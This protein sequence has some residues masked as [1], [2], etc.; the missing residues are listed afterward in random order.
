MN[1]VAGLISS[2]E[3][4]HRT[5]RGGRGMVNAGIKKGDP[6]VAFITHDR[7]SF[8][9][10]ARRGEPDRSIAESSRAD[11]VESAGVPRMTPADIDPRQHGAGL[12]RRQ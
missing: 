11:P 3:L 8:P 4:R 10:P 12:D 9:P 5:V 2:R 7:R 6:V 1:D